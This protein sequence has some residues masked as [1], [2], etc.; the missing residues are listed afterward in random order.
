[1]NKQSKPIEPVVEI[2][3]KL[4]DVIRQCGMGRSNIY[5]GMEE[6]TFPAS[7]KLSTR[8]VGWP[9]S[10]VSKWVANKISSKK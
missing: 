7:I 3:L 10:H 5:K 4:P 9:Q 1:M 6:G 2:L 8:A